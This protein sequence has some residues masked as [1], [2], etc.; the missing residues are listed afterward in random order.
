MNKHIILGEVCGNDLQVIAGYEIGGIE[1]D[2]H[3]T[4][5][6]LVKHIERVIIGR[7]LRIE[8]DCTMYLSDDYLIDVLPEEE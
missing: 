6:K 7:E 1:T 4:T 5:I 8:D 2:E 3:G